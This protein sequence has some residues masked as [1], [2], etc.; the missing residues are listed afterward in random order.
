M[1]SEFIVLCIF[2]F[3]MIMLCIW[4]L[5]YG[6][7]ECQKYSR[8]VRNTQQS[9]NL[10]NTSNVVEITKESTDTEQNSTEEDNPPQYSEIR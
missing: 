7:I 4:V 1:D 6:C 3:C 2:Q 5:F 10:T 9:H 8:S